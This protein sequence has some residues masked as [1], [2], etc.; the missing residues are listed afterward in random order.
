MRVEAEGHL[1][2]IN[3]LGRYAVVENLMQLLEGIVAAL[4]AADALLNRQ[5]GALG[6]VEGADTRKR[7]Q[8]AGWVARCHGLETR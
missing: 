1:Q 8:V 5:A 3:W 4:Q 2:L 6:F 7:R